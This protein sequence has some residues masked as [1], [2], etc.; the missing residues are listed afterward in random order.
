MLFLMLGQVLPGQAY[1]QEGFSISAPAPAI[2]NLTN[3]MNF[4][5]EEKLHAFSLTRFHFTTLKQFHSN[6]F[7]R[8]EAEHVMS[9][10][11]AGLLNTG[12]QTFLL[13]AHREIYLLKALRENKAV[14]VNF[15][16]PQQAQVLVEPGNK[17]V[18]QLK[19]TV[20]HAPAT[21]EIRPLLDGPIAFQITLEEGHDRYV[22]DVNWAGWVSGFPWGNS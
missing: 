9:K 21:I 12:I 3:P 10:R 8:G 13:E 11:E 18:Y 22:Y 6:L 14:R 16:R 1:A 5:P 7:G 4:S 17:E 15:S 19:P 20:T 2:N